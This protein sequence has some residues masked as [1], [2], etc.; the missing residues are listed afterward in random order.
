[1]ASSDAL[2]VTNDW[3]SEFYFTADQSSG[4]FLAA[5]KNLVKE[6]KAEAEDDSGWVS[7]LDR[8]T[9]NRQRLLSELITLHSDVQEIPEDAP[10]ALRRAKLADGSTAI[11]EEL[12]EMFDYRGDVEQYGPL[13]IYS[14]PGI[15]QPTVAVVDA[16]A[17]DSV[18]ELVSARTGILPEDVIFD[19]E[20]NPD[21]IGSVAGVMSALISHT[22]APTYVVVFA[23]RHVL[24]T[25]TGTN[26]WAEGRY[27][28]VDLQTVA[29]RGDVRSGGETQ[30]A[31]ASVSGPSL[32]PNAQ[33]EI[34]WDARREESVRNA[35][36]VSADLRDGVRESIEII[37]NEVVNRRKAQGLDP[38]ANDQAQVLAV[39]SLRYLFRVLFL[40]YAEASPRLGVVP[41]GDPDYESGYSID[42]LRELTIKPLTPSSSD[43]RHFYESLQLLFHLVETGHTPRVAGEDQENPRE[44]LTFEAMRSDLFRPNRTSLIDEVKLGNKALQKVLQ[45]LLLTKETRGRNRGFISYVALGIN[46]LGAVYE[47]LMSYTG[48]FASEELVEVAPHGDASHGS[49]VVPERRL[50][51]DLKVHCVEVLDEE[52]GPHVRRYQFGEFVFRLSGRERQR[53]ASYYS[54]KVLTEFTVQQG[55]DELLTDDTTAQEILDLSVCEPA[56]G[57]GAFAI[58]AVNQ[59]AAAYLERRQREVG[60]S[61][62]PDEYPQEFQKAKTYI[63]L[64]NVYGVDLNP[65]AVELA[66]VSLWLDTMARG[67]KAPWFGLR[68]RSGNSLIGAR[69]AV[70]SAATVEK[71]K[72]K[73][74]MGQ[75][76]DRIPLSQS[77]AG[78]GIFHFLLPAS[79][80]GAAGG[81]NEIKKLAPEP[82]KDLRD[83]AKRVA[84]KPNKPQVKELVSLTERIQY[85]WGIAERRMIEAERQSRRSIDVW[86]A[87]VPAGGEVTREEIE[88]SLRES[89]SAYRRLRLVMD[90]WCA[91]WFWP[92]L[93]NGSVPKPPEFDEWLTTVRRIVGSE[94]KVSK[95]ARQDSYFGQGDDEWATLDHIEVMFTAEGCEDIEKLLDEIPWLREAQRIAKEQRFFHWELDFAAVFARGG[96]DLQVGNPPWVR[97]DLDVASLL[98]DYDPWWT[99]TNK[100]TEKAKQ[101]RREQ[102]L[103]LTGAHENLLRGAAEIAGTASVVSSLSEY[104]ELA[105]TRPDLY[106]NFMATVWRHASSRGVSALVHPPTHFTDAKGYTLRSHT[107][108]HL[109]RHWGF[110]NLRHL[111]SEIDGKISF[112]INIYGSLRSPEFLSAVSMYHPATVTGSL[113]H[114][115]DGPE[116][117]FKDAEGNWDMSPHRSRVQHVGA[118]DLQVWHRVM[119][120]ND[121]KVSPETSRM[122]YTVNESSRHVLTKLTETSN[123]SELCPEFNN[124]WNETIDRQKGLFE[125][126]WGTAPRWKDVILQGPNFHVGNP[127]FQSRNSTLGGNQDYSRM[128]L[129]QLSS[130]ALPVTEYK[131][132]YEQDKEGNTDTSRY[133]NAYGEW[134]VPGNEPGTVRRAPVRDFYRVMWRAMAAGTNERTL[135]PAIFPPGTGNVNSVFCEGYPAAI[136]SQVALSAA[137]MSSLL[138]DFLVRATVGSGIYQ[139]AV[140]RLPR[141]PED[142]PLA[143]AAILRI[144]RLNALTDAYAYLWADCW[145]EEMTHDS[146]TG[147]NTHTAADS[148]PRPELGAVGPQWTQA[149]PLRVDEDRRQALVEID[150]IMAHVTG[151]SID[152]LCTTYRTQFGV[153]YGYDRGEGRGAY[154]YDASGRVIPSTVRTAWN[155]AGRPESGMPEE[156]RTYVNPE[157]RTL[158][159]HEPFRILD[160][161]EDMRTAYRE[162]ARRLNHQ[163]KN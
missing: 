68:L 119:E 50:D 147:G 58:E 20:T 160:R 59:L 30:R 25:S 128:D 153:L 46:Q 37:A 67:L 89:N 90:A 78:Q 140:D 137:S 91:L 16:L 132:I 29:E 149:T 139:T 71:A 94:Y 66:E 5:V 131:P 87:E 144:L 62:D 49:W 72:P 162:F 157:G 85:L 95:Y 41:T 75:A 9:S 156:D 1:M 18:E 113:N 133:D 4:T 65:T 102:T 130:D 136:P 63:A 24:L 105:G 124:G 143:S 17:V 39:Q 44:G 154:I 23:G 117:G 92:V 26:G 40:L 152:E 73:D 107:Y 45:N 61:I 8:F 43:G 57:S 116:P 14:A 76:P 52:G 21:P 19:T 60:R 159:A 27:L 145:G 118:T 163:D 74:R 151:I 108:H 135:I 129:E 123:I 10:V 98:G 3:I 150:A 79:G 56:L 161:E 6:W 38:L 34:W 121:P 101:A 31:V 100:A 69:H 122:V 127:F 104:P 99:L 80:W 11:A 84:A 86:E 155:K 96:F 70:Y 103:E 120:G 15:E 111:F 2:L 142:H 125:S 77:P 93:S 115:G 47:S 158:V 114:N 64:H 146:W 134:E 141:I 32:I 51:E 13:R 12:R 22:P 106:R 109:R 7:P 83:W 35:V 110:L 82:A 81:N 97:P 88:R 36:G 112:S 55:L 138:S 42:R 28:S 33:G 126:R 48:S 54:P 148:G 53:S